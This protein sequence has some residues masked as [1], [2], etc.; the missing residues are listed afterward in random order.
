M[1]RCS[2]TRRCTRR[3]KTLDV[4]ESRLIGRRLSGR[5]ASFPCF[6][7]TMT[8]AFRHFLGKSVS[9]THLYRPEQIRKDVVIKDKYK[10]NVIKLANSKGLEH[11]NYS[12]KIILIKIIYIFAC[13]FQ[14]ESWSTLHSLATVSYTHLDVYKRQILAYTFL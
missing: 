1:V 13:N 4:A 11:T 14:E 8:V 5:E 3:S 9:Y 6:G 12:G 2:R 10:R 7:I